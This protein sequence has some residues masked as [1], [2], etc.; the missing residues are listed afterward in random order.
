M[1]WFQQYTDLTRDTITLIPSKYLFV[2]FKPTLLTW[3]ST[4]CDI[5]LLE[6]SEM[7]EE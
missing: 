2:C 4:Q 3:T 1:G 6:K 5:W 7:H